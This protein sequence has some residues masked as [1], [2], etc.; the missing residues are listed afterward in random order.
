MT[1]LTRPKLIGFDLDYTLWPFWV[2]T[3]VD[4]PFH[5]DWKGQ[6]VDM[7][8]KKIKYYAEV[9]DVLKWLHK[10]GY[11]LA[12]VSRTGEIKGAN[13]LLELFDWD[14]YFTYKEIYPGCKITHFNRVLHSR[15]MK[16]VYYINKYFIKEKVCNGF[17]IHCMGCKSHQ[18]FQEN[19]SKNLLEMRVDIT[20]KD[21]H[22]VTREEE[23]FCTCH[24]PT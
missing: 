19:C 7:Y 22:F 1:E 5:K 21:S 18:R 3:H 17:L 13:Q 8:N 2:D 14:K 20:R 6:V 16:V 4:P 24:H 15:E 9:P 10:E 12:A 23:I 11:V